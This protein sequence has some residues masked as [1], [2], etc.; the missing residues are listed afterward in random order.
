ML[1]VFA[2]VSSLYECRDCTMSFNQSSTIT[3]H[4]RVH[5]GENLRIVANESSHW[6]KAMSIMTVG[7]H[8]HTGLPS[9]NTT[10]FTVEKSPKSVVTVG[11]PLGNAV[12]SLNT[13]VHSDAKPYES[14]ECGKTFT[15][16]NHLLIHKRVHIGEKLYAFTD[17]GKY[18]ILINIC[19]V[20]ALILHKADS[21]DGSATKRRKAMTMEVNGDLIRCSE[22]GE[23]PT[24]IGRLLGQSPTT[25]STIINDQMRVLEHVKGSA[26]RKST[27]VT[28]QRSGLII[29]MERLLV[30]WLE[31]QYQRRIPV[32]LTLIQEKAKCLFEALKKQ[33]GKGS[34]SEEFVASKGW[35]MRFKARANLHNLKLPGEA[36]SDDA[37]AAGDFPSALAEIIMEGGYCDQQ[38]FNVHE[39]GLF[40]K[41]LPTRMYT[42]K[43]EKTAS[44]HKASKERLTLLLGANAAGDFKLK[45]LVCLAEN[46]RAIKGIWKG[47][48]PVIWKSNKKTWVTLSVFEDWFTNHFVPEVKDYC[49]S[50]GLPFK[51]LLVLDSAPCHPA[52]LNDFHPNVKVVYLP[53]NTTSLLQPMGQGVLAS[54]KAYYLRR[55]FAMASMAMEKDKELTLKDFWKSYN[56]LAAVKNISDSWDEVKQTNLNGVWKKLCPQFVNDFHRFEDPVEVVIKNVV[57][58]SKQLDLEVEAED[59]TELLASHGEELSAEDLT[60]LKQQFVEEE[61][62]PTPEPRRFTSKELAGAFAMIEDALARFAAQDPN[63]DRYTKVARGVMDSLRCYKEIWEDTK[64]VSFQ[65]SLEHYYKKVERPTTD[66]VPS[67]SCASPDSP[68]PGSPAPG[69]TASPDSPDPRSP[70]PSAGSASPDSPDPVSHASSAGSASQISSPQQPS[71]S[72]SFPTLQ[73]PVCKTT[74]VVKDRW[75]LTDHL[76]ACLIAPNHSDASLLM[77]NCPTPLAFS[78]PNAPLAGLIAPNC[79]PAG[80]ITPNY[81]RPCLDM[82]FE[83]VAIAFSQEEWEI[84]DEAQRRLYCDVMLQVFALVSFVVVKNFTVAPGPGEAAGPWIRVS[85]GPGSGRGRGPQDPGEPGPRVRARPRAPGSG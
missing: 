16:N 46:P 31:E 82:N 66:P 24:N 45:P 42:A 50:R 62:T 59:V 61:D 29:D 80:M 23:T 27:V 77:P 26:P 11:S 12:A 83:D 41:H 19:S 35:F 72:L 25:V 15:C 5:P 51:V 63:S 14:S 56:V 28:E 57:E 78:P 2:F 21:S 44:G 9:F 1:E 64:K 43:E 47:L 33:K 54:F 70:A 20:N 75:F 60:Q 49:A 69:G 3:P 67:T 53:S 17:Y 79:P 40:W 6:R 39:T 36:A 74:T 30:L 34:E 37:K 58:L 7:S 73:R 85:L 55:T 18:V 48:L 76:P 22:K 52:N 13:R 10:E 8:L 71:V 68:D 81:P 38:V 84:L 4:Q 65:T 32:S